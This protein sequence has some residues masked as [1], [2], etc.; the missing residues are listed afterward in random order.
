MLLGLQVTDSAGNRIG[1]GRALARNLGK[2]LSL[3]TLGIGFIMVG[4]TKKKQG[5]HDIIAS[6]LVLSKDNLTNGER[7][8]RTLTAWLSS[9]AAVMVIVGGTFFAISVFD[10]SAKIEKEFEQKNANHHG[11][12]DQ[13]AAQ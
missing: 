6:A 8:C 7:I 4:F 10:R 11:H 9:I 1:F 3:I 2:I 13:K 12:I 5:L